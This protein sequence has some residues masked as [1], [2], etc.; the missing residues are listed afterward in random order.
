MIFTQ[1][2]KMK[3][4]LC[5][6]YYYVPKS[7]LEITK[8]SIFNAGAGKIGNYEHC[9]WQTKGTGQFKP[10]PKS[11]AYIGKIGKISKISEYRVETLC[12]LTKIKEVIKALKKAHPYECPV[13]GV[14]KLHQ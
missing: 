7:H 13:I 6:F 2:G 12:Q 3:S 8:Q 4:T 5:Y 10:K 11:Q 1:G 14:I 9:T